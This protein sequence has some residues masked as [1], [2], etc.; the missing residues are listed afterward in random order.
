VIQNYF[1]NSVIF[2]DKNISSKAQSELETPWLNT[3]YYFYI[4]ID[5][6]K[7]QNTLIKINEYI[8]IFFK[9]QCNDFIL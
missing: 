8:C 2:K 7:I 9:Y 3:M 1:L 6:L 4:F 5:V